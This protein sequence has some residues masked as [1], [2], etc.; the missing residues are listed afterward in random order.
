MID[1][2][3][4]NLG[5]LQTTSSRPIGQPSWAGVLEEHAGISG[6]IW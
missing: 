6:K 1:V 3:L 5:R 4:N 2:L